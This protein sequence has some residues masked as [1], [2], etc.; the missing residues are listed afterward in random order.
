LIFDDPA[1]NTRGQRP[2]SG[3]REGKLPNPRG[4]ATGARCTHF[5]SKIYKIPRTGFARA[6]CASSLP[7]NLTVV[8]ENV[9]VSAAEYI[10]ERSAWFD[11]NLPEILWETGGYVLVA[12]LSPN[13]NLLLQLK[14]IDY[15]QIF[16]LQ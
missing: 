7:L 15:R 1:E 5:F 11:R 4:R 6:P 9:S 13:P 8:F 12:V 2:R 10:E 3:S 14:N 16:L